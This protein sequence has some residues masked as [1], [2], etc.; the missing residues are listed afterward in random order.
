MILTFLYGSLLSDGVP[1]PVYKIPIFET[2]MSQ[3]TYILYS[4]DIFVI[5]DFSCSLLLKTYI[6]L[7]SVVLA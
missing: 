1:L 2:A 6:L 4:Q 5:G 3:L 7:E